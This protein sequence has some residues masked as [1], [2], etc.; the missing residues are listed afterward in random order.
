MKN[1]I[2]HFSKTELVNLNV[3]NYL[4]IILGALI[5]TVCGIIDRQ[6]DWLTIIRDEI[7]GKLGLP[8][9]GS[10]WFMVEDCFTWCKNWMRFLL[11]RAVGVENSFWI[12]FKNAT[13]WRFPWRR[14]VAYQSGVGIRNCFKD[15][16]SMALIVTKTM[17]NF[18]GVSISGA[19]KKE[20]CCFWK[21]STVSLL[22][23]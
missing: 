10:Q 20:L 7:D 18:R 21:R 2:C 4:I 6:N 5:K 15:S 22:K 13:F 1:A 23:I 8:E 14:G 19:L 9:G 11:S 16:Q 3:L 12:W 17:E